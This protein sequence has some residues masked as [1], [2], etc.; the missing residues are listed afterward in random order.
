MTLSACPPE[1]IILSSLNSLG[2]SL[3]LCSV[4]W[5]FDVPDPVH[6]GIYFLT[7]SSFNCYS[8][9]SVWWFLF[10]VNMM[11][12][13]IITYGHLC[14]CWWGLSQKELYILNADSTIHDLGACTKQEKASR[15]LEFIFFCLVTVFA[16]WHAT[17][18]ACQHSFCSSACCPHHD[19]QYLIL[20]RKPT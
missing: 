1:P 14:L 8:T 3:D 4:S 15:T 11:I 6:A 5:R 18:H 19:G 13:F 17:S 12:W 9:V 20:N 10:F 2:L 7:V 16:M